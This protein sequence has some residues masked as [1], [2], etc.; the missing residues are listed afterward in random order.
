MFLGIA[1]FL[2]GQQNFKLLARTAATNAGVKIKNM[3][4]KSVKVVVDF[5]HHPHWSGKL[6]YCIHGGK[7]DPNTFSACII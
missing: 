7:P 4:A 1:E 5:N 6:R 2:E 3:T